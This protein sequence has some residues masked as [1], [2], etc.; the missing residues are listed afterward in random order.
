MVFQRESFSYKINKNNGFTLAEVLITLTIIGIVAAI[1]LP[2]LLV[3]IND[4]AWNAQR[5]ALYARMSQAIGE[6]DTVAGYGAS[7]GQTADEI[8]KNASETFIIDGLSKVYRIQNVCN[9]NNLTACGI[10]SSIIT[11]SG[12]QMNFPKVIT[13][14]SPSFFAKDKLFSFDK[15]VREKMKKIE[16]AA[17]ETVN[18]ESIAVFYFPYC[19]SKYVGTDEYA[20]GAR[21]CVNMIYDLNG[22]KGPNEVGKD[23]GFITA[24]YRSDPVVVAPIPLSSN[25]GSGVLIP[26]DPSK[27][28]YAAAMCQ[29]QDSDSRIPNIEELMSMTANFALLGIEDEE[30][31]SSNIVSAGSAPDALEIK[32]SNGTIKAHGA[33]STKYVRCVKR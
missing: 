32:L 6:M 28:G 25:A 22:L 23:I 16:A 11:L 13:E 8:A 14:A 10:P 9:S 26:K 27:N 15:D 20:A 7:N 24:L 19:A 21:M 18:G 29:E 17:F 12:E 4:K 3:N 5:K 31:W 33:N 30:Y 2:S 1:T